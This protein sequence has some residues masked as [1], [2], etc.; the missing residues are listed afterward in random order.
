MLLNKW[1]QPLRRNARLTQQFVSNGQAYSTQ[2]ASRPSIPAPSAG[3]VLPS[4]REANNCW[5]VHRQTKQHDMQRTLCGTVTNI[6]PSQ[7]SHQ[8]DS[9]SHEKDTFMEI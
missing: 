3:V 6:I 7:L 2:T 8:P 1:L 5:D 9:I 4:S